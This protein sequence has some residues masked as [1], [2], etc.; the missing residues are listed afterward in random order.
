MNYFVE[1][2]QGSGKST[3][4]A[5]LKQKYPDHELY[6]EGSYS[7]I[8]LAWCAYVDEKEYQKIIERYPEMSDAIKGNCFTEEDHRIITYTRIKTEDRSFYEDLEHYEIYNGRSDLDRFRKIILKRYERYEG[9]NAIFECSLFQNIIEDLILFQELDDKEIL[10]FYKQLSKILE[11]KK[12]S[13]IYLKSDD[14]KT[15]ILKVRKERVDDKGNEIWFDLLRN[16]F[17][18]SPY[19]LHKGV[20]GE[21]ALYS[22]LEHRQKLELEICEKLF[23]DKTLIL[24]SKDYDMDIL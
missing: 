7:P 1:G 6:M 20:A 18:H 22:H 11:K 21:E 4:C 3:L 14:I 12:M 13:I 2:S 24:R 10:S 8:E 17:D 19:A 15:N 9:E 16:Y 5:A 23:K